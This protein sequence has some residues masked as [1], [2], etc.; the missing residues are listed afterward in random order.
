[1]NTGNN[2][3]LD[4]NTA[5]NINNAMDSSGIKSKIGDNV[6]EYNTPVLQEVREV[7]TG[8]TI[9]VQKVR[10][11]ATP[12][13]LIIIFLLFGACYYMYNKANQTI[14]FYEKQYSPINTSKEVTLDK[15]SFLVKSLYNTVKTDIK[16]DIVMPSYDNAFKLY[17]AY[18]NISHSDIYESNCNMFNNTSMQSFTCKVDDKDYIPTAF[19]IN[20]MQNSISKIF[21]ENAN[22]TLGDLQY[23]A[24][25]FGGYQYIPDR[26]E[27][28]SGKCIAQSTVILQATKE[29]VKATSTQDRIVLEEKVK[30]SN[31]TGGEIPPELKSGIYHYTFRLDKNYNYILENK[32]LVEERG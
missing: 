7:N 24:T 18:R 23:G 29:I 9:V 10:N 22:V 15:D 13:F 17:I 30:Y 12:L 26:G 3:N 28:V 19:K 11:K 21:G 14:S 32:E 8:P 1:M 20:T 5:Q 2:I 6:R 16:E 4:N 31:P 25:C 27:F